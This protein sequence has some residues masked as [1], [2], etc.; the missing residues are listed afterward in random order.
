MDRAASVVSSLSMVASDPVA[1]AGSLGQAVGA[2]HADSNAAL[3]Q[4]LL[5]AGHDAEL[6]DHVLELIELGLHLAR[7]LLVL[8]R[9]LL[10]LGVLAPQVTQLVDLV[11]DRV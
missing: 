4:R 6:L 10:Q 8:D 2:S 7:V 1:R 5:E 11:R 3:G 9:L